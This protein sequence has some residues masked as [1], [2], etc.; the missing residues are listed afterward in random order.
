MAPD[1]KDFAWEALNAFFRRRGEVGQVSCAPC[2]VERLTRW[3]VG[4]FP[5]VAAQAAVADAFERPG[6]LRVKPGEPC[7]ACKRRRRC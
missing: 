5:R 3:R 4:A 6:S 7:E 2:L 1:D